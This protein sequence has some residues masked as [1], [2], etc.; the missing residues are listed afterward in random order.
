MIYDKRHYGAREK[1]SALPKGRR[2][3]LGEEERQCRRIEAIRARGDKAMADRPDRWDCVVDRAEER[4]N[5]F[6]ESEG[7]PIL[8]EF[9]ASC[10]KR[11][12]ENVFLWLSVSR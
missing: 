5:A 3:C 2:L 10:T 12:D 1:V 9:W 4:R 6:H 8:N 11:I 7:K